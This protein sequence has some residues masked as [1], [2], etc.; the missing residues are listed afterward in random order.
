MEYT[1][2]SITKKEAGDWLR[3]RNLLWEGDDHIAE[4]EKY[5]SGL[6][7]EPNEVLIA[8]DKSGKVVGHVELSIR[9]D[10]VGLLG[11]RT[12]YIEGLYL[13]EDHRSS[14]LSRILLRSSEDWAKSQGCV[15]F[16]SDREDRVIIHV[17]YQASVT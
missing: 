17:K 9:E 4:I 3:L 16:A 5:F 6:A 11:K 2:S 10:V 14:R 13:E 12:G 15:A 1:I 7:E 8:K